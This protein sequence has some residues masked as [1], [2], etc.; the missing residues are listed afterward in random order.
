VG[1]KRVTFL[2]TT[3]SV[4]F[5]LFRHFLA[6]LF[7]S[8][9]F[10]TRGE[11][12]K[13]AVSAF[14]LA[15]PAGMILLDPRYTAK[16]RHLSSFATAAP[17]RAGVMAD[18]LAIL[19]LHFSVVGLISLLQWQSLFP[20]RR[21]YLALASLPVRHRDIFAVRCVAVLILFS[22]LIA[23]LILAPS[24]IAPLQFS[25]RWQTTPYVTNVA[26]QAIASALGCFFIVFAIIALQG[27]LLNL[28]PARFFIRGSVFVQS[29]LIAV[30]FLAGLSGWTIAS[31]Q[32]DTVHIVEQLGGWAP[33]VWFA[34]LYRWLTGDRTTFAA[35]MAVRA[36][37]AF[38]FATFLASSTYLVSYRCY[39]RLLLENPVQASLLQSERWSVLRP[40]SRDPRHEAII[41]FIGK[42]LTRSRPHRLVLLAYTGAAVAIVV[43]SSLL[44]AAAVKWSG[45]WR[46]ALSFAVL[47]WPLATSIILLAGIRHVFRMPVELPANWI[48][49]LTEREGRA[50][51]MSAIARFVIGAVILPTHLI[52]LPIG[53]A[54]LGW[55]LASRMTILQILVSLTAFEFLF[56]NWQQLP[57][58][59]SYVPGKRSLMGVVGGWFATLGFLVPV[60]SILVATISQMTEIF[61]AG[62]VFFGGMWLWAR[63]Y[64]RDGWGE[65]KVFFEDIS[66]APLDLHLNEIGAS[67]S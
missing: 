44:A 50:Q 7:D 56:Q 37:V 38:A 1:H 8:E 25:G 54:V 48:F 33:P 46:Q 27:A 28:L 57:F 23:A 36:I 65:S 30:F 3:R 6:T 60:L 20:T 18:E 63:H 22:L 21:D 16:Y 32:E 2:H 61:F 15:I 51:W 24:F 14:A 19:T 10:S 26:A 34:G 47:Y 4:R 9:M 58:S 53:I 66:D 11:W 29:V 67:R 41:Q 52:L 35:T 42:T 45:G 40:L 12:R 59:C 43:N 31:W 62:L 64:R 55:P 17:F 13:V 5:E 49:Q 39:R